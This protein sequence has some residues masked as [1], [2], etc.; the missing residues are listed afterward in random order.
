[1]FKQISLDQIH[2]PCHPKKSI[3]QDISL[4]WMLVGVWLINCVLMII[5]AIHQIW[6]PSMNAQDKN[7]K[8]II[9]DPFDGTSL[10][11]TH[12]PNWLNSTNQNKSLHFSQIPSSDIIPIPQYD[13][14]ALLQEKNQLLRYTYTVPYM[15]SYLLNYKEN[16]GSHLGVDIRAPIGTPVLSIAN[17]VVVRALTDRGGH[18]F[19]VIRHDNVPLN[20]EKTTLFSAYLHLSEIT[21]NEGEKI[22]KGEMLGRVGITGLTTTPHLHFQIDTGDAPFHPYWPFSNREALNQKMNIF[23]AV[24]SG[25]GSQNALRYTINPMNYVQHYLGGNTT[26]IF[27]QKIPENI[28][29]KSLEEIVKFSIPEILSDVSPS[30]TPKNTNDSRG[31]E[32]IVY[33]SAPNSNNIIVASHITR[34][35][36]CKNLIGLDTSTAFG[37]NAANLH[38]QSCLLDEIE[39]I[40]SNE[41][42]SRRNALIALM[43]HFEKNPLSGTSHFLDIPLH[44]SV[45]QGYALKAYQEGVLKNNT[46]N[47]DRAITKAEFIALI[48]RLG[49][50]QTAPKNYNGIK[51]LSKNFSL[52]QALQN[53][54]F[55]IGEKNLTFTP[56]LPLSQF[57][58]IDILTRLSH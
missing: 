44:D 23:Q 45:L 21:V 12:I 48:N 38:E 4:T 41:S 46:F 24:S 36:Q 51:N 3:F 55:T 50:L 7:Y 9:S 11:I 37:I 19:V 6:I 58:M 2:S 43:K 20:G 47:P 32:D 25:L 5:I 22:R 8:N 33:Y 40:S 42:V 18:K 56:N 34:N 30:V 53:Y 31:L 14:E 52:Y 26:E 28:P 54:A 17:G 10:P 29:L 35:L 16:D 39:T 15:G 27:T 1:M 13:P 57:D 49:K